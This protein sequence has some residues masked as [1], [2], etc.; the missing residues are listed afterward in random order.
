MR[1]RVREVYQMGGTSRSQLVDIPLD[2]FNLCLIVARSVVYLHTLGAR[3]AAEEP[4]ACRAVL[5]ITPAWRASARNECGRI[6]LRRAGLRSQLRTSCPEERR[7]AKVA[8]MSLQIPAP[9][10]SSMSSSLFLSSSSGN[11]GLVFLMWGSPGRV[12]G[13]FV[14][15][16]PCLLVCL[17]D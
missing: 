1:V 2:G 16:F 6:E 3:S 12:I 9:S 10:F 17:I 8:P 7:E 14:S 5:H 11:I 4:Q 15:L 13:L